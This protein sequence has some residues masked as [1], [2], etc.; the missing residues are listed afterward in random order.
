MGPL[1]LISCLKPVAVSAAARLLATT[2]FGRFKTGLPKNGAAIL[3]NRERPLSIS[4]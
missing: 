2:V 4:G 1:K 3:A